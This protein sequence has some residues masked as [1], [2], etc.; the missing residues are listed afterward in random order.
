VAQRSRKAKRVVRVSNL[1]QNGRDG[2]APLTSL[3]SK[4]TT[5]TPAADK[6]TVNRW[7][8]QPLM[9]FL[10]AFGGCAA[11]FGA[12]QYQVSAIQKQGSEPV[13]RLQERVA[14]LE[15]AI[16]RIESAN[17]AA[18]TRIESQVNKVVDYLMP[19]KK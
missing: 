1:P 12:L 18:H 16:P 3:D 15:D 7:W 14:V 19:N 8:V 10:F 4:V 17:N 9:T 13:Q 11:A 5:M 6:K 2:L